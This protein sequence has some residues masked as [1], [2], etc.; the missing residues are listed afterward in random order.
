MTDYSGA[1][2]YALILPIVGGILGIV[3]F[4]L[5]VRAAVAAGLR[6]HL[7]WVERNRPSHAAHV[8]GDHPPFQ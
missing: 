5:V 7:K 4:Y 1:F 2:A 3:F 8:L 6:D